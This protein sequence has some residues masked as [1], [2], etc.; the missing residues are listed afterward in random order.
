MIYKCNLHTHTQFCDGKCSMEDMTKDAIAK[1][2]DTL[3]FSPHSF[4]HF[5]TSYCLND[6]NA[7]KQEFLRLKDKYKN[8]INLMLGIE[9][10]AFGTLPDDNFDYVIGSVH[11]L[12]VKDDFLSVFDL[13]QNKVFALDE[14]KQT[15]DKLLSDGFGGDM[16]AVAQNYFD[17]VVNMVQKTKPTIIGHFDLVSLYGDFGQVKDRYEQIATDAIKKLAGCGC[18]V[19]INANRK[20]KGKGGLYPADFLIT[21]F[22][23]NGFDFVWSSD[24]HVTDSLGFDFDN[25]I[26]HIKQLGVTRLVSFDKK[27]NK[28]VT[29]I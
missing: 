16:I 8:D 22:A 4:T 7:F 20:F 5:D 9:L 6:Y 23:K 3:G 25:T 2:F 28:V 27:G 10:D 21:E 24:A 15:F 17:T 18:L 19:E 12:S 14:S 13:Q 29:E 26:S 11:Y 1:G